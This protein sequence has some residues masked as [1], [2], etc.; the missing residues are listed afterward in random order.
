MALARN[1]LPPLALSPLAVLSLH[2]FAVRLKITSR[3]LNGAKNVKPLVS[4]AD[5]ST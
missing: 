2:P 3:G 5:L 4:S 1:R